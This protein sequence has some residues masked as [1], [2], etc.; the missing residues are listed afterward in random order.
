MTSA[1]MQWCN[2]AQDCCQPFHDGKAVPPTVEAAL[3]ARFSGFSKGEVDYLVATDRRGGSTEEQLK[4]DLSASCNNLSYSSLKVLETD[5]FG[6]VKFQYKSQSQGKQAKTPIKVGRSAMAKGDQIER[7][8]DGER[9][10]IGDGAMR[11]RGYFSGEESAE[12]VHS[13]C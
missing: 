4:R 1:P 12:S 3:R 8:L 6:T 11:N 13:F 10:L 7:N 2:P 5:G 9:R